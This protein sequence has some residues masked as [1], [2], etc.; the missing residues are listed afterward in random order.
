MNSFF[1]LPVAFISLL[2][3]QFYTP[4]AMAQEP[5]NALHFDGVNDYVDL[6]DNDGMNAITVETWLYYQEDG[7]KFICGKGVE[8][9]EIHTTAGGNIRFIPVAGVYI[10]AVG[11][12]S[13]GH[14]SHLAFVYDPAQSLAKIYVNG[15]EVPTTHSGANPLTTPIADN[16][17]NF[18]L[19][20]RSDGTYPFKGA[21]DEF[22]IWNTA[23]TAQEIT[24]NYDTVVVAASEPNLVSYYKCNQGVAGGDNSAVATLVDS[25]GSFNGTL[26]NMDLTG[27]SSNF[28]ESYAMVIPVALAATNTDETSFTANWSE[29]ALGTVS[30]YFLYVSADI[31]FTNLLPGYNPDTLQNTE[32]SDSVGGLIPGSR[33]Y[34]RIAAYNSVTGNKSAFSN[35][36]QTV[37]AGTSASPE[38]FRFFGNGGNADLFIHSDRSWTATS[39]EAWLTLS[40]AGGNGNDTL[41]LTADTN[42][43]QAARTASIT[44]SSSNQSDIIINI[45]QGSITGSGTDADPFIIYTYDDLCAIDN[46]MYSFS[47]VYQLGADIDASAS[48]TQNG[49]Q[50]FLPIGNNVTPFTGKFY[51]SGFTINH[52]YINR[53]GM[54]YI[55]LFGYTMGATFSGLSLANADISGTS[56]YSG[57]FTGRSI[58]S[59]YSDC[60]VYGRIAGGS[61]C[62]GLTGYAGNDSVQSCSATVEMISNSFC[63]GLIG[64]CENSI[65]SN[66]TSTGKIISS[67]NSCGGLIASIQRC[68][69]ENSQAQVDITNTGSSCSVIGGFIGVL[70]GASVGSIVRNCFS[71]GNIKCPVSSGWEFG[72]FAGSI[73]FIP[74]ENC[75]SSGNVECSASAS[76]I[77]GFVGNASVSGVLIN[78][79]YATGNVHG[80]SQ[81]GGFAGYLTANITHCWSGGK[82]EGLLSTGGFTGYLA[83]GNISYCCFDTLTAGTS[84][85]VGQLYSGTIT[86]CRGLSTSGMKQQANFNDFDFTT[87]WQIRENMTCPALQGVSD[88]APF[89]F[90]DTIEFHSSS[91]AFADIIAT[92]YDYETL[93][94]ALVLKI[95]DLESGTSGTDSVF[96]SSLTPVNTP[97]TVNYR[98]GELIQPGDTL[99]GNRAVSEL[100]I[101]NNIPVFTDL[102]TNQTDEDVALHLSL[103]DIIYSDA[104]NDSIQIQILPGADYTVIGTDIMP[105][106][107]FNGQIDVPV[108]ISDGISASDTLTF[109]ITVNPV[110]DA[111]VISAV[112]ISPIAEDSSCLITSADILFSDV[113]NDAIDSIEVLAGTN[114]TFSGDTIIPD[115]NFFGNLY[116]LVRISD[117]SDWSAVYTDTIFVLNVDDAPIALD[118][119][120]L[121]RQN[122]ADTFHLAFSDVDNAITNIYI[123]NYP[124]HG[125]IDFSGFDLIYTPVSAYYGNDTIQ[126][127]VK[128]DNGVF[129]NTAQLIISI[130][131]NNAPVITSTAPTTAIEGQ[132]YT[133]EAIAVDSEN[134]QLTYSLSNAPAGMI[135]TD[136]I[137]TWTPVAGTSNSGI[138]TLT[139]SDGLLSDIENFFVFVADNNTPPVITS[140][141]PTTAIEGQEYTYEVIAVDAE[142]DNLIYSL[143]NAPA[144]M[145]ITDSIITWTP[146]AGTLNS[147]IVTLT[148]SDGLLSDIENFIVFVSPDGLSEVLAGS[149]SIYPNPVSNELTIES[150]CNTDQKHFEIINAT[151]QVVFKDVIAGKTIVQT[152]NFNPGVYLI[153]FDNGETSIYKKIIKE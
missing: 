153:K 19:G 78:N 71:T 128:S 138:V 42:H 3:L 29:P 53:P 142:N 104:D 90:A 113:E 75:W 46:V 103:S 145:I 120:V 25:T 38:S 73:V 37:S 74:V 106:Q 152:N 117:G 58:S 56:N 17:S 111:P 87:K 54:N 102:L 40:T 147:G 140:T 114:Y 69:V 31:T 51:G 44:I 30:N 47:A 62:G 148:V 144:G 123:D 57:I 48:L 131:Q 68:I 43:T 10:D 118:S 151:G 88:N 14:W 101:I 70:G 137:I 79:C 13:V 83:G 129:S 64:Y 34:Y 150:K 1:K 22:R 26:N 96:F 39:S 63:G 132:E 141:A 134:D 92:D 85:L 36:I 121:I 6:G 89:A 91:V 27:S 94:T 97:Y 110:N 23:R 41:V 100:I 115:T 149:I 18:V 7:L 80:S 99:W 65:I 146:V 119:I 61:Y 12:L 15:I 86:S 112:N 81:I 4:Q 24:D 2:I 49:G 107:D 55:G 82:V 139:V 67:G 76:R 125:V 116:V 52:L 126:W 136:S 133:Y 143:S 11:V 122:Q 5:G 124:D 72:G 77:G 33:Y 93:Q 135:I 130:E 95:I 32:T 45:E 84:L 20:R 109:I 98:I 127:F 105:A 28:V 35:A 9:L 59:T 60:H 50:G 66:C 21:V 8:N 16:T 108:F